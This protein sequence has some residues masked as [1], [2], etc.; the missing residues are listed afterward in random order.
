MYDSSVLG[1]TRLRL[2]VEGRVQGVGFRWF[3]RECAAARG[4]AGWTRNRDDGSVEI[5]AEG[6]DEVLEAF[7]AELRSGNPAAR[8]D[9]I[10]A[11]RMDAR[12]DTSFEIR[13]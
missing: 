3:V 6:G 2:T 10:S 12:G 7:V 5:E 11:E 9:R 1:L 8:V 13:R 4:V